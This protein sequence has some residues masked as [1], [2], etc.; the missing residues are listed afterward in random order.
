MNIKKS[1]SLKK[2]TG[3]LIRS[4]DIAPNMNWQMMER[5][6][7]LLNKFNIKPVL[8]IIPNNKDQELLS[9]PKRENFWKIVQNWKSQ[10]W[11]IAMHGYTHVYDNDT[12]KKD[13][14]YG[15]KSEF[16]GHSLDEQS[17]IKKDQT[18]LMKII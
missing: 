9:Y 11:S 6:E 13:F 4:D 15:G 10:K 2:C 18:Y 17:K 7:V 5:R 3:I 14:E 12:N 8:G 1:V 16:Y